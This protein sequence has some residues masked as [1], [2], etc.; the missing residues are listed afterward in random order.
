MAAR[1]FRRLAHTRSTGR[2]RPWPSSWG[3]RL[4]YGRF[5]RQ[6]AYCASD[7]GLDRGFTVYEDYIFPR[8]TALKTAVLVDRPA[9]GLE[10]LERFL[11]EW[12]DIGWL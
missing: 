5:H 8:L 6:P 7:S 1:A 10:T 12:L 11:E 2:T 9:D 4:C 3:A